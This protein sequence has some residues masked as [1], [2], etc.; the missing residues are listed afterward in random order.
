[1]SASRGSLEREPPSC[2]APLRVS[3][4]RRPSAY[5]SRHKTWAASGSHTF[6]CSCPVCFISHMIFCFALLL[7]GAPPPPRRPPPRPD[8]DGRWGESSRWIFRFWGLQ[9]DAG[10]SVLLSEADD[11]MPSPGSCRL[12]TRA[13]QRRSGLRGLTQAVSRRASPGS[14]R[15]DKG[16]RGGAGGTGGLAGRRGGRRQEESEEESEK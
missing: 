16:G 8:G 14:R 10:S 12:L 15:R 3:S 4:P 1:M 13:V 5:N 6:L 11:M 9:E 7:C 2:R